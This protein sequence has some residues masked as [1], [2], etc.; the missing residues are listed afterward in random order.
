[1]FC[2]LTAVQQ[3][4]ANQ[5]Y[6][7]GL[8]NDRRIKQLCVRPNVILQL[9]SVTE[10]KFVNIPIHTETVPHPLVNVG[11]QCFPSIQDSNLFIGVDKQ[12]QGVSIEWKPMIE[13]FVDHQVRVEEQCASIKE[14]PINRFLTVEASDRKIISYGLSSFGYD[15]RIGRNFK[16]FTNLNS[17]VVDPLNF[18]ENNYVEREGDSIIIPP[19][20]FVLAHTME[21]FNIPN[22]ILGVCMGK[23]TL[24]RSGENVIVTPLEPGWPGYLTLEYSNVTNLPVILHAGMGGGQITFTRGEVPLVTYAD[25]G[26]KYQNQGE[27][28]VAPR[29]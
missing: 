1:M 2:E 20:S 4:I 6:P 12:G 17:S 22:D 26:G 3:A 24:A 27:E 10:G 7:M 5:L 15:F 11:T 13:G 18:D 16:L 8:L 29:L 25:R 28:A 23:S 14:D 9:P 19:N 21:R